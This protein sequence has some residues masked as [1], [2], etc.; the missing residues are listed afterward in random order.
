MTPLTLISFHSL[1]LSLTL[2]FLTLY[3]SVIRP[4]RISTIFILSPLKSYSYSTRF[5]SPLIQVLSYPLTTLFSFRSCLI[6]DLFFCVR[7]SRCAFKFGAV[8][9]L[10]AGSSSWHFDIG[11]LKLR[12]LHRFGF[13][14]WII[15]EI[16][17]DRFYWSRLYYSV[18]DES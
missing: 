5:H 15:Q 2:I 10:R 17:Q 7:F 8:W 11:G 6:S 12:T 16:R 14:C 1:S 9:G 13:S 4:S 3:K 18:V